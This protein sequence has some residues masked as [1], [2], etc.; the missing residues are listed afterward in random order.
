MHSKKRGPKAAAGKWQT[1][2]PGPKSR[3]IAGKPGE[4]HPPQRKAGEQARQ[5][6][7][8]ENAE[9][10]TGESHA[11]GVG[12]WAGTH[13]VWGRAGVTRAR[14]G[15]CSAQ[16]CGTHERPRGGRGASFPAPP[17]ARR[18]AGNGGQPPSQAPQVPARAAPHRA[19]SSNPPGPEPQRLGS[20]PSVAGPRRPL[21]ARSVL[22]AATSRFRAGAGHASPWCRLLP[23]G[24]RSTEPARPRGPHQV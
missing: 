21:A 23:G 5:P 1:P 14:V 6:E 16:A 24:R 4:N 12:A 3:A 2:H 18:A 17:D 8:A 19:D 15:E 10:P 11:R 20:A 7:P 9:A 13:A 22:A